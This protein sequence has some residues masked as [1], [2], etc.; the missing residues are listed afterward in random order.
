MAKQL[1]G[2]SLEEVVEL[3]PKLRR[4]VREQCN[5]D[6]DL[7]MPGDSS[8]Q[9]ADDGFS[10]LPDNSSF[11]AKLREWLNIYPHLR[12]HLK[13]QPGDLKAEYTEALKAL[14]YDDK[15]IKAYMRRID[16]AC[17]AYKVL[18]ESD[19]ALAFI[20][21]LL[22]L[23]RTKYI[24]RKPKRKKGGRNELNTKFPAEVVILVKL[25][26]TISGCTNNEEVANYWLCYNIYLRLI[27][28][29]MPGPRYM[30]SPETIRF[31]LKMMPKG[32]FEQLLREYFGSAKISAEE[33][34][35][36]TTRGERKD[37]NK[38]MRTI[39]GDGQEVRASFRRGNN[40]RMA[41]C[42]SSVSLTDCDA[43]TVIAATTEKLKNHEDKAFLRMLNALEVVEDM[44]F[45]ADALNT[46]TPFLEKLNKR[47]IAWFMPVKSTK[48]MAELKK[49]IAEAMQR[50]PYVKGFARTYKPKKSHGR[51]EEYKMKLLSVDA[52][53][54]GTQYPEGTKTLMRVEKTTKFPHKGVPA[55]KW[56]PHA[57]GDL[58]Y[59]V[60]GVHSRDH[61]TANTLAQRA[62]VVRTAS[63]HA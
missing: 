42:G 29:N 20:T 43:V 26:A 5:A 57:F 44:L 41:K 37:C 40:N 1:K 48:G 12:F 34:I 11:V 39:G 35:L 21:D 55:E 28:P 47:G 45:Y 46:K 24:T 31:V 23:I 60:A 15:Q 53:P 54:T 3:H 56:P 30:I 7:P 16:T 61:G 18:D 22:N 14:H 51:Q 59:L 49:A 50:R 8:E 2:N 13:P 10:E 33:L 9:S 38:F 17:D 58:L 52:L 36:N 62:L 4:A 63:P 6:E 19:I 32:G 27:I 25:L